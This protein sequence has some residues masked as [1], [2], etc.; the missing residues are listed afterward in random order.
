MWKKIKEYKYLAITKYWI[1][2]IILAVITFQ[3]I[4]NSLLKNELDINILIEKETLKYIISNLL[5][6]LLGGFVFITM[7]IYNESKDSQIKE[8][9]LRANI[10][11]KNILFFINNIIAF[12][13]GGFVYQIINNLFDLKGSDSFIQTLFSTAAIIDYAGIISAM[14][15]L[16]ILTTIGT[17]K[18]LKLLY[19]E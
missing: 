8:K 13:I 1:S 14:T 5:G 9:R 18:R 16:S 10:K 4:T 6:G 19:G 2:G 12:S 3:F 15:V 7:T 11:E 17:K